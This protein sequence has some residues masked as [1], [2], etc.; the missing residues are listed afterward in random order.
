MY[1]L[2]LFYIFSSK[3]SLTAE[4]T[5]FRYQDS[6]LKCTMHITKSFKF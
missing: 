4:K 3:I 6:V 1:G 5:E 2:V